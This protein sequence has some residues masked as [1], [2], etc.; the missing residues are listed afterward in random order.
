MTLKTLKD[1]KLLYWGCLCFYELI[2]IDFHIIE[3]ALAYH[4]ET[5]TSHHP[6]A[7]LYDRLF[8]V[9]ILAYITPLVTRNNQIH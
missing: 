4:P 1:V 9:V 2:L 3:T 6:T 8:S 7:N 5:Q